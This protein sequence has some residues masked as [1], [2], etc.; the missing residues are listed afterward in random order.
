MCWPF[1]TAVDAR[2]RDVALGHDREANDLGR[3]A[4]VRQTRENL[5]ALGFERALVE[6]RVRF[7]ISGGA[8]GVERGFQFLIAHRVSVPAWPSSTP[9]NF[10]NALNKCT[11]TVAGFMPVA[12][13]I[14]AGVRSSR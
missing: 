12:A 1:R 6:V 7:G 13:L 10:R 8:V 3:L 5:V 11:R 2:D 4:E 14:S 9:R